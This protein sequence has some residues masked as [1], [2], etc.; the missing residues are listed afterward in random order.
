MGRTA[1]LDEPLTSVVV[2]IELLAKR[3]E[4]TKDGGPGVVVVVGD[5]HWGGSEDRHVMRV[6]VD[7]RR[8][9]RAAA[10]LT[11]RSSTVSD[12]WNTSSPRRRRRRRRRQQ[13]L[14]TMSFTPKPGCPMCGIVSAAQRSEVDSPVS[15]TSFRERASQPEILW[16]DENFTAYR[17]KANPVSSKGHVVIAFKCALLFSTLPRPPHLPT[18]FTS[19]PST[20][21]YVPLLS[22]PL[23][24]ALSMPRTHPVVQRPPPPR[25]PPRHRHPR[26]QFSPLALL[27]PPPALS[28]RD[29]P[30][31]NP[32]LQLPYRLHHAALPRLQNSRHRPS[33]RSRVHRARRPHGLVARLGIQ[34]RRMVCG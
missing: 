3:D 34:R 20:P 9:L 19:P 18:A 1:D 29:S 14:P 23:H 33:P 10:L 2:A 27:S 24:T 6:G 12:A 17:E 4:G 13:H 25:L 28:P 21:S 26:P 30:L 7:C 22:S 15:P 16:R 11:G 5:G 32:E 31:P 8:Q